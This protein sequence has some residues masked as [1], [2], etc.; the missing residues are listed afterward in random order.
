MN[1]EQYLLFAAGG[2]KKL[3][4]DYEFRK[5]QAPNW[6]RYLKEQEHEKD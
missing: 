6:L 5:Y 1:F 2:D 4:M 3:V